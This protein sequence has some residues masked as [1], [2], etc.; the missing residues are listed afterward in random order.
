MNRLI[1][2]VIDANYADQI[3]TEKQLARILGGSDN[4][5]YGLVKRA[6]QAGD[7]VKIKRGQYVLADRHRKYPVHPFRL[8]QALVVGSYVS[9]E[10]A[11]AF[12]GWIPEAVFATV[13][14]T[15]GRKSID[16]SHTV[17]GKFAFRPLALNK[18]G[19]LEGVERQTISNQTVL[20]AKPLRALFDLIA[21][22]KHKWQG[23]GWISSGM[24]I[25]PEYL[26]RTPQKDFHALRRVYKH[27]AVLEFLNHLEQHVVAL[28]AQ[29]NTK[30]DEGLLK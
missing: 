27:K 10:S 19:F 13:S 5:R 4:S 29:K 9:M 12:H 20:V 23:M 22:K 3:L 2:C 25:D 21:L 1:Q 28:K 7:L 18:T 8:A 24:R 14:V 15:P 26:L 17:F 6:M 16:I 11:L 30:K